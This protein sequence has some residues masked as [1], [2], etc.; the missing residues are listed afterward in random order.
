MGELPLGCIVGW[1]SA[2]CPSGLATHRRATNL[3]GRFFGL[4]TFIKSHLRETTH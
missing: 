1:V 3:A 2:G 4:P